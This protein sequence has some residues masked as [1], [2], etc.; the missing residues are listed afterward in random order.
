VTLFLSWA[1]YTLITS[2]ASRIAGLE[3]TIFGFYLSVEDWLFGMGLIWMTP[4]K[5]VCF[6]FL[7]MA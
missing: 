3:N 6:G 7:G 1:S 5:S 2:S 4:L